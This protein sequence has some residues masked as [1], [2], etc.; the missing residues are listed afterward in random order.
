MIA[1]NKHPLLTFLREIDGD[2]QEGQ[3]TDRQLLQRF[4][5][6]GDEHAFAALVRRHAS[7]VLNTCRRQLRDAHDA[8]DAFQAVFMVLARKA[9]NI[10]WQDSVAGWLHEVAY[11]VAAEA[12]KKSARRRSREAQLDPMPEPPARTESPFQEL[13][14]IL[15]T[16]LRRLPNKYRLPLVLCCLEGRSRDEAAQQLGWT[17]GMVKGRLERGRE[18]LRK[19]L[20]RRGVSL[21]LGL[22]PLLIDSLAQA[23][24]AVCPHAVQSIL[25]LIR[26]CGPGNFL[27]AAGTPGELAHAVLRTWLREKAGQLSWLCVTLMIVGIVVGLGLVAFDGGTDTAESNTPIPV[28][29]KAELPGQ[30]KMPDGPQ[31]VPAAQHPIVVAPE[32]PQAATSKMKIAENGAVRRVAFSP[33]SQRLVTSCADGHVRLRN[34]SDGSLVR[35]WKLGAYVSAVA[36]SPDG[37]TVAAGNSQGRLM[38]WD[39]ESGVTLFQRDSKFQNIYHLAYSPDGTTLASANHLGSITI[40]DAQRGAP[41]RS[42]IAHTGRVWWV[43]FRPDGKLLAS[44]GEDGYLRISAAGTG[45]LAHRFNGHQGSACAVEFSPDGKTIASA[46]Y[47]C[48]ITIRN[49]EEGGHMAWSTDEPNHSIL[50][51]PDGKQ[52]ISTDDRGKVHVWE[53]ATGK[54][55]HSF[56]AAKD[57]IYFAAL[58]P[59]ARL[60]ATAGVAG[61][62]Q[63]WPVP[64]GGQQ[65]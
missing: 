48:R 28:E 19:R 58:N 4:V 36:I 11:R 17:I 23:Q 59:Q 33:T 55:I 10:Q 51:F 13:C 53:T 50:F 30:P 45:E 34:I 47:D 21:S 60:L 2:L 62:V 52:L 61:M 25:A 20:A 44:A 29:A 38:A 35:E 12:R 57:A 27:A 8:E 15:D 24:G 42:F 18:V 65:W 9:G 40:W 56:E 22:S 26:S 14:G 54:N 32:G 64:P 3:R 37:K 39:A 49:I 63:T 43:S 7:L 41:K 6:M 46:G 16:E 31:P 5:Q 1:K